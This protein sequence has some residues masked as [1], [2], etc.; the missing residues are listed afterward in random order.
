MNRKLL[1][2]SRIALLA[3]LVGTSPLAGAA[4]VIVPQRIPDTYAKAATL[5]TV[6]HGR[7]LN[8]RCTGSGPHTVMLEAGSHADSM[9]WFKL[10]PLLSS[11]TEVCSYDRAG[12]GFSSEGPQ[13]RN[14]DADVSD[15]HDLIRA[16][17]IKTPVVLVG[18]SLG[19]NI[20]RQYAER[21]TTDVSGMV[22]ID[23][24]EQNVA[25]FAPEWAKSDKALN[26]QRFALIRQCETSAEKGTLVSPP[27]L[28]ACGV[29]PNPLAS[30]KLNDVIL[31][32]KS[33]P[34]FWRTLLSELKDNAVVFSKPVSPKE[35]HGS[36]PLIVLTAA[37]TYAGVP[38]SV[39]KALEAA[40][41]KTQAQI[42]AT[43]TRGE[44]LFVDNASH[45]IQL[46]QPEVV[47]EAIT[48]VLQQTTMPDR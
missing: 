32:K 5:V 12:Y 43:S 47:A 31:A 19:S 18:H 4:G 42:V 7:Q 46:D 45:D 38:A 28:K 3:I 30:A 9:T 40:R 20:V 36:I 23:P 25:A 39:R 37:N 13:P 34:G 24:P 2:K 27:A 44:R 35:T 48:K 17:G 33:R 21:Y 10:Q 41:E 8:L 1:E 22:L 26:A 15:L 29:G 11:I 16:A 14:L 6:A